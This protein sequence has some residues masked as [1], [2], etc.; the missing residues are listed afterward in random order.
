MLPS[1]FWLCKASHTQTHT[2]AHSLAK[3]THSHNHISVF[4]LPSTPLS[5][6]CLFSPFLPALVSFPLF[7]LFSLFFVAQVYFW[8]LF[9]LPSASFGFLH[10]ASEHFVALHKVHWARNLGFFITTSAKM[11]MMLMRLILMCEDDDYVCAGCAS[12]CTSF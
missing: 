1:W 9:L 11:M 7:L 8:F 4:Q 5:F 12:S 10:L 3:H 6:S 2:I